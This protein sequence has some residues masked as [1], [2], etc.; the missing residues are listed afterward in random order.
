[1]TKQNFHLT[2][3]AARVLRDIHKHS[4]NQWGQKTADA[5]LADLYASMKQVATK[6][7]TGPLR[8]Y[9]AAPFLMV[10]GA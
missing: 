6:P 1:M 7:G 4:L 2:R 5:Y 3:Q 9:R 8:A 10:S